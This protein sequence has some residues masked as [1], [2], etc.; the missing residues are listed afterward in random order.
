MG[1]HAKIFLAKAA[2]E[3]VMAVMGSSNVTRRAFGE[4]PQFNYECDVVMWDETRVNINGVVQE[5]IADGG[6]KLDVVMT[7]YDEAHPANRVPLRDR[8]LNLETEIRELAV[9]V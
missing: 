7:T 6:E 2:G 3:P 5:A 8:V 1:W 4:F 9:N